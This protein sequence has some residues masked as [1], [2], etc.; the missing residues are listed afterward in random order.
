MEVLVAMAV[1][2]IGL[3]GSAQLIGYSIAR[4]VQARKVS[5][6][7]HLGNEILERLRTEVRFDGGMAGPVSGLS[8]G[9]AVTAANA[10]AADRLPY[11]IDEAVNGNGGAIAGCNPAGAVDPGPGTNYGVGPLAFRFEGNVYW[12]CYRLAAAPAG[13]PTGSIDA[14]VK[15]LWQ[16]T[17]G[18]QA[19]HV[20]AVLVGSW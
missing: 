3:V 18:V 2:A 9:V 17:S 6:A 14:L 19:R 11:R 10:W 1:L 20:S 16:G 12:V 4:S 13:Y 8:E 5:A 15:V 7:Q